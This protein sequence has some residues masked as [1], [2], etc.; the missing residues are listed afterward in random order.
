M[1]QWW[2]HLPALSW[3]LWVFLFGLI[4][5]SFLN[6]V[7][8]RLYY[9][10][11]LLWPGS[12]CFTCYSKLRLVDNL[13]IIGYLRLRGRCRSCGTRFSPRYLWVEL[14]TGVAFVALFAVD[15]LSQT[16]GGPA[17]LKPWHPTPGL[18]FPYLGNALSLPPWPAVCYFLA[19]AALISFLL[20][21][22][23]IDAE[24]REIPPSLTYTGA[25]VGLIAS[26]LLP[27]PWPSELRQ[28]AAQAA[29]PWILPDA[30]P[31]IPHGAMPWPFWGPPPAWAPPGSH[32]LGFLNGV[33]G[34]AV[35]TFFVRGVKFLFEIGARR[36][37]LGLGDADLLLMVGAFLGWQVVFV[38]F[39][40][41]AVAGLLLKIPSLALDLVAKREVASELPF[42]PGLALGCV[43]AWLAWPWMADG[44]RVLYEPM[45]LGLLAV[46]LVG[47]LLGSGL[48]LR[49]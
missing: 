29:L 9:Q 7:V 27:W 45:V 2:F 48:L 14:A 37:A 33:I 49:R 16:D 34:A 30:L 31:V 41:G 38:G 5:G 35:G 18:R 11:S 15:V 36:P 28:N 44:L 17:F 46:V 1:L 19:H 20:A 22:A 13:P 25:A 6:V 47:G 39:F 10:K 42:G 8:A 40:F 32:L 26:T 3:C 12:R 21:A 43:A 4:V 23:L 24:H